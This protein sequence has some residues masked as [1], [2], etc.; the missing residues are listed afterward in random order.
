MAQRKGSLVFVGLGLH[1]ESGIS[2]RGINEIRRAEKIFAESYT[3]SLSEGSLD[4]LKESTGR[5]IERLSR[6]EVEDGSKILAASVEGSVVLLVP[7]DP[8]TATTHVDLRIRA[9]KMGIR[10]SIVHGASALTAVPGILGLQS[11]KFGRATTVPYPRGGYSPTS[12]LEVIFDNRSRGLHT[13]VLLDIDEEGGRHMTANEGLRLLM[14]MESQT[15]R[16]LISPDLLVCVVARAGAPDCVACAGRF[17]DLVN[18]DYGPPLHT[19]VVPGRLHFM[20][21]EALSLLGQLT[22]KS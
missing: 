6:A 14:D 8:M 21:E 1:D 4:R 18:G 17:A 15:G 2:L 9:A 10:T 19:I 7:G 22:G 20:E 13:L 12:P 11:Y 3:S 16:G 5:Q